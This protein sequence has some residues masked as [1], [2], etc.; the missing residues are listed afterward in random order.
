MRGLRKILLGFFYLGG[1][2]GLT[3]LE[4]TK[5]VDRA[6]DLTGMG[7]LAG[8]LA[9]GVGAIVYGNIQEHKAAKPS[10]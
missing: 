7:V 10:G 3:A 8:G 5:A 4:I 2:F 1:M 9:V 6:P